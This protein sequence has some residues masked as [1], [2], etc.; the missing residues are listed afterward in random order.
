LKLEAALDAFAVD[1]S[2]GRWLDVGASTGG[3]TDCLLQRGARRVV[4]VDVGHNQLDYRVRTDPRVEAREGVN[5]RYLTPA[6][7]GAPFD[8]AVIDVSFISLRLILPAVAPLVAPGGHV[9]ALVK[10]QFEVGRGEVGKGG[11]V[12][13]DAKRRRVV[14]EITQ[15]ACALGLAPV[16]AIESP[17]EGAEGNREFLLALRA[18]N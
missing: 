12:R 16:G 6:D 13:D 18:P 17:I 1:P 8:G 9:V 10:P 5:A 11:I 2:G 7:F 15:F 3:F 4:A 14:D